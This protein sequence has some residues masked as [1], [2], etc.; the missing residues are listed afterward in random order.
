MS[1]PSK[2][3]VDAA[4]EILQTALTPP[5]RNL[6][7]IIARHMQPEREAAHAMRRLLASSVA[8]QCTALEG[9]CGSCWACRV[10]A[11]IRAYR[12]ARGE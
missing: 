11:A 2:A 4:D 3:D 1:D 7:A 10:N 9:E 8:G 6:A 5:G 12:E